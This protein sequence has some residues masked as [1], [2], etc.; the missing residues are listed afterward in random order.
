METGTDAQ[1]VWWSK[2]EPQMTTGELAQWK[3]WKAQHPLPP[4]TGF[5][6]L[7]EACF[8]LQREASAATGRHIPMVVENVKG[9]QPWVGRARWHY[10]SY[11]LWGDVPALMPQAFRARK[12]NTHRKDTASKNNG[13]SWFAVAHNT[14]SGHSRNPVNCPERGLKIGDQNIYR[15]DSGPSPHF[16][17]PTEGVKVALSGRRWFAEGPGSVSSSSSARK[18]ASAQIAMI[19]CPLARWIGEVYRP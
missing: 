5:I 16:T 12:F 11:F 18:E 17:N 4:P 3:L 14:K 6:D 1:L 13:G 8:R 19:P 9:A 15:T 2:P 10:G 7:F